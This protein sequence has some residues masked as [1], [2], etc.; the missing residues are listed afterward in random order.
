MEE[1]I[2]K[3]KG[4]LVFDPP[5]KSN[6]HKAQSSWKKVAYVDI[7][8]H[9]DICGFYRWLIKKRFNLLLNSPLRGAHVTFINDKIQE[10]GGEDNW[11]KLKQKWNG[12]MVEIELDL[13]PKTDDVNWWL[14]VTED[15]RK[16]LHDIRNEVDL[17]RPYWGLHM[18]VGYAGISYDDTFENGM[19]KVARDNIAHSKYIHSLAKN[20]FI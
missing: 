12:K 19:G 6:K 10:I 16:L 14:T 2:I 9:N 4:K 7:G 17:G 8:T 3:V 15:S 20:N 5:D 11:L 1:Y 13:N 18:T